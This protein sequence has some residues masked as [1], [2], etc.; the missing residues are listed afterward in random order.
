MNKDYYKIYKLAPSI[1]GT[2]SKIPLSLKIPVLPEQ[3]KQ[4]SVVK[5]LLIYLSTDSQKWLVFVFFCF[6]KN[7]H[8][9]N[10]YHILSV[11]PMPWGFS[12]L[13]VSLT[14]KILEVSQMHPILQ[15]VKLK[16]ICKDW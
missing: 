15:T 14:H 8:F 2:F 12:R 7:L 5:A 13:K 1:C 16:Y 6:Y 4:P 11:L 3:E 10:V 9:D